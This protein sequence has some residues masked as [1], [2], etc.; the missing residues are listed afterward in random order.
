MIKR[1]FEVELAKLDDTHEARL[2]SAEYQAFCAMDDKELY[3]NKDEF[4]EYINENIERCINKIVELDNTA[5]DQI[6]V[7]NKNLIDEYK[8]RMQN[9]E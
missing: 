2:C 8:Q 1:G 9:F 4:I 7:S 6:F 3:K 5:D